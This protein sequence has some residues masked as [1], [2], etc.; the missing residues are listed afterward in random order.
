MQ[1]VRA[2]ALPPG[3]CKCL[4]NPVIMAK[5]MKENVLGKNEKSRKQYTIWYAGNRYVF[6]RT[7]QYKVKMHK[8]AAI[9]H[10]KMTKR[11][12]IIKSY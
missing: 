6:R 1:N 9:K 7:K 12:K 5:N 3:P 4:S 11:R 10:I 8:I 2:S